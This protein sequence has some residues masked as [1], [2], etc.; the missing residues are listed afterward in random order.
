MV[1]EE[2]SATVVV[3]SFAAA[4][5]TET[6]LAKAIKAYAA[7]RAESPPSHG[8]MKLKDLMQQD[9]GA[10]I[11]EVI[12]LARNNER[13]VTGIVLNAFSESFVL[14]AKLFDLV[15]KMKSMIETI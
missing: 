8:K 11:L 10:N 5:L 6:V 9:Q 12:P 4:K 15:E 3:L 1:Y 2:V 13:N 7:H 14:D